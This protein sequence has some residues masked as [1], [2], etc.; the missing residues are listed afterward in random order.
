MDLSGS[1]QMKN[2]TQEFTFCVLRFWSACWNLYQMDFKI[3]A[4]GVTPI[5]APTNTATSYWKTSSLAVPKGPSTWILA[6]SKRQWA[7][8]KSHLYLQPQT[9]S[10]RHMLHGSLL[11]VYFNHIPFSPDLRFSDE[12]PSLFCLSAFWSGSLLLLRTYL[13]TGEYCFSKVLMRVS[14]QS[15]TARIWMEKKSSSGAEVRVKGC[16]SRLE[17]EG[18]LTKIYCPTSILKPCLCI[19]NSK[20]LDGCMTTYEQSTEA[21]RGKFKWQQGQADKVNG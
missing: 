14:V 8:V 21:K 4:K 18:Q 13:G 1:D 3:E 16:H 10:Q 11:L 5:P 2:V 20:T 12:L 7:K 9:S 19:C 6:E 17:I 15:P